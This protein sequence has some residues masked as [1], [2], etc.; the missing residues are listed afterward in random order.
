MECHYKSLSKI[1][2]NKFLE[3][4]ESISTQNLAAWLIPLFARNNRLINVYFS[5]NFQ[6]VFSVAFRSIC[7]Q[8]LF[9]VVCFQ[10]LFSVVCFQW[11]YS[12]CFSL[13]SSIFFSEFVFFNVSISFMPILSLYHSSMFVTQ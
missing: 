1:G 12:V 7:F 5:I 10:W 4:E 11:F 2:H 3:A 8:W 9:S 6:C 13:S